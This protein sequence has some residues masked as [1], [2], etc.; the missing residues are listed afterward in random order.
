VLWRKGS[1][2]SDSAAGSRFAERLLTLVA[3]CRPAGRG[4]L[5]LLVVANEAALGGSPSLSLISAPLEGCTL[6]KS[7]HLPSLYQP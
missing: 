6:P 1:F 5:E 4:L 3:T 7:A 2:D